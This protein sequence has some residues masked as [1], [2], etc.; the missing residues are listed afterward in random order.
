MKSG[1]KGPGFLFCTKKEVVII[2]NNIEYKDDTRWKVYVYTNKVNGKK[3][4]GQTCQPIEYRANNG[5]G[6][7]RC[8]YFYRAIEKYGWDNFSC[9]ILLENLT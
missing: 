7:K 5:R 1:C 6:Y 4:V 2:E 3:Y 8:V 9:N